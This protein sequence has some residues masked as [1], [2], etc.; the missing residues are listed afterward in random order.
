MQEQLRTHVKKH[1]KNSIEIE[2]VNKLKVDSY[3]SSNHF[4]RHRLLIQYTKSLVWAIDFKFKL[5]NFFF[6]NSQALLN[7]NRYKIGNEP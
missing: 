3:Y 1:K 7:K 2:Q 4:Y 5:F 6:N